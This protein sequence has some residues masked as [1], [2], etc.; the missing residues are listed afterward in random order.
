MTTHP[1]LRT[2]GCSQLMT[3]LVM[4]FW[5]WKCFS[6]GSF[7]ALHNGTKLVLKSDLNRFFAWNC[8]WFSSCE[9][10]ETLQYILAKVVPV[11]TQP[12]TDSYG[13]IVQSIVKHWKDFN[14]SPISWQW[15]LGICIDKPKNVFV[16]FH[17]EITST[18]FWLD[19]S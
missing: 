16:F 10:V 6:S 14:T 12:C 19:F 9:M 1:F 5:H 11:L 8:E 4:V 15:Y 7:C 2:K 3:V 18:N 13:V 17:D